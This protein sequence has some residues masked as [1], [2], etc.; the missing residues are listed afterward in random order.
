MDC[1]AFFVQVARLEDPEGVGRLPLLMVGGSSNRGVVTSISYEA[2]ASGARSGMPTSKA[3]R[4]CPGATVVPVPRGAV[5]AHSARVRS[6]LE[7]MCPVVQAASID[8][9]YIDLTG[10]ERLFRHESL[11]A[12]AQRL[13]LGVLGETKISVSVG[14]S[15]CRLVSK[16]ATNFAKPAG[17]HCVPPGAEAEFMKRFELRQIPGIGPAFAAALKNKG[18]INVPD[19]LG[20]EFEW[21]E[22]WFGESRAHWLHRRIRGLDAT[23]VNPREPRKSIS[24]ERTFFT[25]IDDD[26]E[27]ESR[28][29]KLAGSVGRIL[30]KNELRVRTVTVKLRDADFT[31]RQASRTVDEAIESDGAIFRTSCELLTELRRRRRRPARLLGVGLS[32]FEELESVVEQ[33]GF[34]GAPEGT[35]TDR[36]RDISKTMDV[37]NERFGDGTVMPARVVKRERGKDS[38]VKKGPS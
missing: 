6:V 5:S 35:E 11:E 33:L 23:R 15:T 3:L 8:E 1:D 28:V 16:L 25:D 31:T 4:L 21:L 22:R 37:L 27:L 17:V 18:L 14:G 26:R 19:A 32:N 7:E 38:Q 30:R 9:F 12:T 10:T 20:V 29:M 34:F 36:E 24:S 13:R 2:R